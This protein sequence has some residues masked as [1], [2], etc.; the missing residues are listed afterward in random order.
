MP[1]L[2]TNILVGI[3][4]LLKFK[5][6]IDVENFK[7]RMSGKELPESIVFLKWREK[8]NPLVEL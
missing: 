3:D 8:M 6:V 2:A 1:E 7:I 4:S 5:C